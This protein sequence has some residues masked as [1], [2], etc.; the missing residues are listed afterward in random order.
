VRKILLTGAGGRIGKAVA[1]RLAENDTKLALVGRTQQTLDATARGISHQCAEAF[2]ITADLSETAS[3]PGIVDHAARLMGGIDTL[4]NNAGVFRFAAFSET[5]VEALD[6]VIDV[7][8]R[9]VMHLTQAALPYLTRHPRSTIVNISSIAAKTPVPGAAAYC[10][11][12]AGL[13]GFSAALFDEVRYRG[14]KICTIGPGQLA[15]DDTQVHPG[16]LPARDVAHA[17]AFVVDYPSPHSCPTEIL[18][19]AQ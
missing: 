1:T 18:L 11:T 10:A 6:A 2:A 19:S 3:I 5:S 17:V 12:K 4:I 7:N 16:S 15:A 8:L 13:F 14:V 9:A